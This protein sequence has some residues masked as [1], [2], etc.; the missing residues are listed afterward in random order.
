M[1]LRDELLN[2]IAEQRQLR[3]IEYQ[4]TRIADGIDRYL[5]VRGVPQ[6]PT[7]EALRNAPTGTY[8]P[9]T[10]ELEMALREHAELMGMSLNDTEE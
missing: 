2:R 1:G 5:A 3:Q 4:L 7:A 10:S 8:V 9:A 6:L